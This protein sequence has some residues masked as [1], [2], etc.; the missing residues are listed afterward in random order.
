MKYVRLIANWLFIVLGFPLFYLYG[1]AVLIGRGLYDMA[2]Q[3]IEEHRE[4][5]F[6]L[7]QEGFL[8]DRELWLVK[9]E[10]W[11]LQEPSPTQKTAARLARQLRRQHEKGISVLDDLSLRQRSAQFQADRNET[12]D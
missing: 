10:L 3:V 5:K 11:P 1:W 6:L 12:G 9:G 2:I 8:I 7:F 4:M